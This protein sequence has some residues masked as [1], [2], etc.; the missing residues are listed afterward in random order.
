MA[1]Q[2]AL[3]ARTRALPL[4]NTA[5]QPDFVEAVAQP[6]LLSRYPAIGRPSLGEM[7]ASCVHCCAS[8]WL[9]EMVGKKRGITHIPPHLHLHLVSLPWTFFPLY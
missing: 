4:H 9:A 3:M 8:C 5:R 6:R 7:N 2:R 1:E